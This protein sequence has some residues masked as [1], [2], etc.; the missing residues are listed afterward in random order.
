MKQNR[1][2]FLITSVGAAAGLAAANLARAQ[3]APLA[4]TDPQA[5]ALGY[6]S[7]ATKAD[8]VKY[9][10]YAAGQ[11]CGTCQL[12]QGKPSDAT[13]PCALFPGKA[14]A[15]KGWCSAWVKKA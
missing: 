8:K 10:K 2:M 14:V 3:T 13:G 4:E 15:A 7:D 11:M 12:F 1:R 6:K 9:P 5:Q